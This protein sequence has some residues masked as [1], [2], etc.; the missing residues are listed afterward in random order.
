MGEE[1]INAMKSRTQKGGYS[2]YFFFFFFLL[3]YNDI[4][5]HI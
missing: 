2:A 3:F 1:S 5:I 4:Q